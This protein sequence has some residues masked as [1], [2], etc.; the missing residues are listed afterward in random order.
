MPDP[1]T[2]VVGSTVLGAGSSIASSSA[3]K[4]AAS[5][6]ANAE[7]QAAAM[8]IDFQKWLYE[9]QKKQSQPWYDAGVDAVRS[10]QAAI[11]DGSYN[12]DTGLINQD[13]Y[14]P[15]TIALMQERF[16]P[17][18]FNGV[19]EIAQDP[20]YQFRLQEGINALDRSAAARGRL[21]S[22]AQA[23]AVTRYGQDLA[24]QEYQ[25]AF[26]RALTTNQTNNASGL[27]AVQNNNT[28]ALN[29]ANTNQ[30]NNTNALAAIQ[31]NNAAN[32]NTWNALSGEMTNRYNRTAGVAGAGQNALNT[33]SNAA[34]NMGASVGN[35]Y[36]AQG[37]AL[38]N[39]YTTQGNAT[40][41]MYSGIGS[42]I[43]GGMNNYFFAK[44]AG[45]I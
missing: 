28:G 39:M 42:S 34:Q 30:L 16:S 12:L 33:I 13:R 18:R 35:S 26:S 4:K 2:A 36:M 17:E 11:K 6:A 37:N 15:N 27:A 44:S 23:K 10:L 20:S 3:Q 5:K 7:V 21:Q 40:A 32:L 45:M 24:S 22:G 29:L 9:D 41:N 19:T 25:N 38:A 14:S 31:N 1:V 43:N 8:N